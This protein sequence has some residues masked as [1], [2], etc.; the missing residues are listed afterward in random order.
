MCG[1]ELVI[2]TRKQGQVCELLPIHALHD[3]FPAAFVEDYA[4]WLDI[5]TGVVEWRPLRHAWTSSPGNWQMRADGQ[6]VG[7]SRGAKR[8]GYLVAG[9]IP[10]RR[11]RRRRR[12]RT[13]HWS[14]TSSTA[15]TAPGPLSLPRRPRRSA[16]ASC[17][18]CATCPPT[19]PDPK[20]RDSCRSR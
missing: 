17:A 8:L 6:E 11:R 16:P 20:S 14:R 3:D 4:H 2:R 15:S 1:P 7:L 13:P 19:S 9:P 5:D 10:R 12:R 18:S